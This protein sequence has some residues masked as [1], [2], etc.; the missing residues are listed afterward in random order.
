RRDDFVQQLELFRA[1]LHVQDAHSGEIATG[2]AQA[3]DQP[4]LN[5]I[6]ADTEDDRHGRSRRLGRQSTRRAG[7]N[8]DAHPTARKVRRTRGRPTLLAT[9]AALAV[10]MAAA[11]E[12]RLA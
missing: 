12:P 4:Y 10:D 2:P 11:V 8:D 3:G 7:G 6:N 9:P 5:G 1:E